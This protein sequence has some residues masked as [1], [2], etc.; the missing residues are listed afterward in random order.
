[1]GRT[2]DAR[3]EA[4]RINPQFKLNDWATRVYP[5]SDL[6]LLRKSRLAGLKFAAEA[7]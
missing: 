1:M 2:E 6:A 3:S 7:T 4:L 5:E